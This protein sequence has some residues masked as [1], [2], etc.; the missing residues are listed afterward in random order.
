KRTNQSVF[1]TEVVKATLSPTWNQHLNITATNLTDKVCVAVYDKSKDQFLGRTKLSFGEMITVSAKE[2]YVG[3]WC[4]LE[5]RGDKKDK[6]IGGEVLIEFS[7]DE[8]DAAVSITVVIVCH[9]SCNLNLSGAG[10]CRH[11]RK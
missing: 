5:G 6:Y 4:T 3:R 10:S 11:R 2:G 8:Q 1:N 7:L 9:E